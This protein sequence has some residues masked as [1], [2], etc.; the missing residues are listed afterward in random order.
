MDGIIKFPLLNE[1]PTRGVALLHL[2]SI[3]LDKLA[4]R[5]LISSLF[6]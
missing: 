4:P 5:Y 6:R 3:R 1:Y 2:T